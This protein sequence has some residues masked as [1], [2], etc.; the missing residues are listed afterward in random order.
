MAFFASI[1]QTVLLAILAYLRPDAVQSL[2]AVVGW[3]YGL[4]MAVIMGYYG[5]TAVEEYAKNRK[6]Q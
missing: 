6:T 3:S 5:N 4:Y 1:I 2:G